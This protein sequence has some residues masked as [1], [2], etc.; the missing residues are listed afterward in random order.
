MSAPASV[1]IRPLQRA[2]YDRLRAIDD[3]ADVRK[4]IFSRFEKNISTE[5]KTALESVGLTIQVFAPTITQIR[6]NSNGILAEDG[7]L[8]RIRI[9]EHP[10]TNK[11]GYEIGILQELI[12]YHMHLWEPDLEAAGT[13]HADADPVDEVPHPELN[14]MDI[15]FRC[16]GGFA[17]RSA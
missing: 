14:I 7:I 10:I 5:I 4:W 8:I 9:S 3:L 6:V 16:T 11:T 12:L 15:F 13:L 1:L 2:I 17:V